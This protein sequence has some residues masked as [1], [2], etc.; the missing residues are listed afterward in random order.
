MIMGSYG[1]TFHPAAQVLKGHFHQD[2]MVKRQG[3]KAAG[4][5]TSNQW[6]ARVLVETRRCG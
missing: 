3:G 6:A 4:P 1:R 5:A 2:L